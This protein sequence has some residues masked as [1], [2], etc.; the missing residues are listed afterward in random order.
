MSEYEK[1]IEQPDKIVDIDAKILDINKRYQEGQGL[2]ILT[3]TQMIMDYQ[4]L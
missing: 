3:P 4:L 2:K 1:R